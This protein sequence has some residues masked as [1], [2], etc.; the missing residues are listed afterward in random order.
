[1]LNPHQVKI[2]PKT[3]NRPSIGSRISSSVCLA[4]GLDDELDTSQ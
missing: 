4:V 2:K 1:M 3:Q